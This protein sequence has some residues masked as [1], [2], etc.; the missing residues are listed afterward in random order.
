MNPQCN[1]VRVQKISIHLMFILIFW[2]NDCCELYQVISIHLMFILI[3]QKKRMPCGGTRNFNTS[4]VY[5]NRNLCPVYGTLIIISIHLMFILIGERI[6]ENTFYTH[7]NTSH[8]YI[9]LAYAF[10]RCSAEIIS[11][12]LMFILILSRDRRMASVQNISIHL[13]F[14]LIAKR[15]EIY[16]TPVYISIHLMFILIFP[17]EVGKKGIN[18]FQYISCLY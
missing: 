2:Q 10:L 1:K 9:N 18:L 17:F 6:K 12:H 3:K 5:I 15:S 16:R 13:M 8:V 4:H 14:I 11:I 7:F